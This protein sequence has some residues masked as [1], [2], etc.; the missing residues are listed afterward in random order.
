[1]KGGS[2]EY[3]FMSE[4]NSRVELSPPVPSNRHSK[5]SRPHG[6]SKT[7]STDRDLKLG[8]GRGGEREAG[9]GERAVSTSEAQ[10]T[11]K[12]LSWIPAV[13]GEKFYSSNNLICIHK[14]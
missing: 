14:S 7:L 11:S 13:R 3:P 4:W 1:M 12:I 5:F 10:P 8:K 9:R 2:Q 6:R